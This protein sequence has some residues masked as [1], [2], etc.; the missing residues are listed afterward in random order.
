M[1]VFVVTDVTRVMKPGHVEVREGELDGARDA[2]AEADQEE[3]EVE[4]D[5]AQEP[6]DDLNGRRPRDV[7]LPDETL[8]QSERR[9]RD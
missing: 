5:E 9:R 3:A 7:P 4:V 1:I 2:T 6:E 8:A